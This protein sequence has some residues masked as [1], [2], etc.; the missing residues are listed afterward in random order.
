[1]EFENLLNY[2]NNLN[3]TKKKALINKRP[4]PYLYS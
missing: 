4:T 3:W 1:M 2:T